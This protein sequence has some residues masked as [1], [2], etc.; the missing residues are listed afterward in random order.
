MH[1]TGGVATGAPGHRERKRRQ[2]RL[3]IYEEAVRLFAE[4]GYQGTTLAAI[5]EAAELAPRTFFSYFDSKEQV[6]YAPYEPALAELER[7]LEDRPLG[8][9]ALDELRAWTVEGMTGGGS[10]EWTDHAQ[11]ADR[12]IDILAAESTDVAAFGLQLLDRMQQRLGRAIA[13]DLDT[14]PDDPRAL[15]TAAAAA[16]AL[17]ASSFRPLPADGRK[18][19]PAQ[20]LDLA[21]R[22]TVAG[23]DAIRT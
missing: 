15:I 21:M 1:Y 6:V 2:T 17:Y 19:D 11:Q 8:S 3:R 7:R 10:D 23:L 16:S 20:I 18:H 5:C 14:T 4:R 9:S 22:F 13:A 12:M